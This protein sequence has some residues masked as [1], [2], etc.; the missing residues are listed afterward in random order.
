M[1]CRVVEVLMTK[2]IFFM[3]LMCLFSDLYAESFSVFCIKG[4]YGL[5]N[6]ERAIKLKAKYYK[7]E[8]N[9]ENYFI[10]ETANSEYEF[11]S[12]K[13]ELLYKLPAGSSARKYS[14]S[15]YLVYYFDEIKNIHISKILNIETWKLSEYK[16]YENFVREPFFWGENLAVVIKG[17]SYPSF[18]VIDRNENTVIS[19]LKQA[20]FC[21]TEGL[22]PVIL[23]NGQSGYI[24]KKGKM[25]ISVPLYED[26]RMGGP[27]ISPILNYYFSNGVAVFQKE[28]DKWCLIDRKANIKELPENYILKTRLYSKGLTVIEDTNSKYGYLNKNAKIAIPCIF[29]SASNFIGE[30]AAVAFQGKDAIIDTKGNIFYSEDLKK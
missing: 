7:I 10:C 25:V 12:P 22:L 5:V 26:I 15:E 30:Y 17:S 28:K 2:K 29:D 21:F 19:N 18:S 27:K 8:K 14:N 4:L 11:Y 1:Q 23:K 3:L 20:G 13:L 24:N 16:K 6:E 9:E